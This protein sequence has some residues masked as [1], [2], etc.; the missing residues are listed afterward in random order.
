MSSANHF[1]VLAGACCLALLLFL[2]GRAPGQTARTKSASASSLH[3]MPALYRAWLEQDVRWIVRD[4]ERAEYQLLNSDE[5]RDNF[6]EAFWQRRDPTPDS[7]ENEFKETHYQRLAYANEHFGAGTTQGW[8][9]DRGHAYIVYGPPDQIEAQPS[10]Q[11]AAP[12]RLGVRPDALMPCRFGVTTIPRQ[13]APASCFASWIS[14]TAAT[15][16]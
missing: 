2:P 5:E 1:R 16:V 11:V 13:E 6:I 15:S 12:E 8:E 3:S 10:A 4:G 9:S 7:L 14:A